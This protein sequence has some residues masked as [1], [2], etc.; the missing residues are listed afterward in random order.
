MTIDPDL[1]ECFVPATFYLRAQA[2]PAALI[3]SRHPSRLHLTLY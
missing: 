2:E 3:F 1:I